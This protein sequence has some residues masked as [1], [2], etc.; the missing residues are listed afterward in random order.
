M[1]EIV[2]LPVLNVKTG[3]RFGWVKD[4]VFNDKSNNI[5][6]IILEKDSFLGHDTGGIK[7]NSIFAVGKDA[8]TVNEIFDLE[9]IIGCCWSQKIGNTVFSD[10]GDIKGTVGDIFTDDL[11]NI[12][13][14]YEITDGLFSDIFNGRGAILE[15]NIIAEGKDVIVIEG[16]S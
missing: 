10:K 15:K 1:K 12:V 5:I 14:G 7:R 8:L 6:G 2:G 3:D 4:I 13:V 11:V 16:G 9:E